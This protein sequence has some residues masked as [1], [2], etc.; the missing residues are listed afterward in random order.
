MDNFFP[1]KIQAIFQECE[2]LGANAEH[3]NQINSYSKTFIYFPGAFPKS[4]RNKTQKLLLGGSRDQLQ[5][6]K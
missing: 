4:T 3:R 1:T 2:L 5:E 6:T